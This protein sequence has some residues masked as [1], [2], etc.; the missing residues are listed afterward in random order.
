MI[1]L[2]SVPQSLKALGDFLLSPAGAFNDAAAN[3][4]I[5]KLYQ[6][7]RPRILYNKRL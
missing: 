1:R 5:Q 2:T 3:T 4:A 7:A 6:N